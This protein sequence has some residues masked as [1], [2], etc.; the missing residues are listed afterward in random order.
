[1]KHFAHS[2]NNVRSRHALEE[3]LSSVATLTGTFLE[4]CEFDSEGI[5]AGL[6]HDLGKYGD[7]F[8]QRLE[9]PNKV[10]GLDHWSPGAW[11][12]LTQYQALAA[13]FAIQGHHI[14]L[15][16]WQEFEASVSRGNPVP[17]PP[18][19]R[20]SEAKPE[21]L[22]DHLKNSDIHIPS[23]N[24]LFDRYPKGIGDMLEIRR[25]FSALTDAD[26]I[27]TEAHFKGK[28]YRSNGPKLEAGKALK[29]VL[30][31]IHG[32]AQQSNS[33]TPVNQVRQEL[34]AACLS[35]AGL[36]SGL[37]TLS[38]PT[39][40]GKTL[41]MLAFALKHAAKNNLK[42]VVM[43]IPYLTIIEQTANTY[44]DLF[45]GTF[46]N[47]Y[48]L[49]HHSLAGL[50]AETADSDAEG[51]NE[52]ERQRRLLAQNWDAPIIVTTNVQLLESLFSNRPSTCRKLH[53]LANAVI[54]F[55]EAQTL[56]VK[57]AVPTLAALSHLSQEWGSSVI[58]ST[59]TQPAFD[60]LNEA[61]KKQIKSGW[62]PREIVPN[63]QM[64]TDRLRRVRYNWPE[65][66]EP[67]GWESLADQIADTRQAL[68]ILNLKKH[69]HI[70]WETLDARAVEGLF[71][72]STNLCPS[73]RHATLNEV[74]KNLD[75]GKPCKL[76]ATQCVEAGVDIDFPAVWRA[77]GPLDAIIQAAG[78]CNREGKR[79]RG[80]T[81]VFIPEQ[82]PYPP[83]EGYL[84]A[85]K[86]T[87]EL[88]RRVGQEDFDPYDE[89]LTKRYYQTL[90]DLTDPATQFGDL[91]QAIKDI[92]FPGV[93]EKYRLIRQDAINMVVPYRK[94]LDR[95]EELCTQADN[96]GLSAEWIRQSRSLTVSL[97]RPKADAP[98]WNAMKPVRYF[99]YNDSKQNDWFI[100]LRPEDYHEQL[101]L[102]PPE[103]VP[104]WIG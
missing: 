75:E 54:L 20:L 65:K 23:I 4:G 80:E 67:L 62:Q 19:L 17:I 76:I 69:A 32:I 63:S 37:F 64:M 41:S 79:K 90:Y 74:R 61:V 53:R 33:S 46:G 13:A 42:R 26:F 30:D 6:L 59:A 8:Q 31:Y 86:I 83:M 21:I 45:R 68:C 99:R 78:R 87:A 43:V 94:E 58:F 18:N 70:V 95:Y 22:L 51:I 34:L 96:K 60:H 38:A 88:L 7:L 28:C 24:S 27:D 29:L 48:V 104:L 57:L 55:D 15:R 3:H 102:I 72:L 100:Y 49:E 66:G 25:L 10:T 93:A 92:D 50:G 12:A 5:L 39:G 77:I 71:Y 98:I 89:G 47:H 103:H 84:Q 9:N 11:V 35:A 14:G 16:S 81:Y 91:Q 101:G 97:Y 85:T 52:K 82:E 2:A 73:H 40:S 44:Q 36:P 56:P 1:M